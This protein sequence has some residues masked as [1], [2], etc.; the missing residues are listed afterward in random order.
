M[1]SMK[2]RNIVITGASSGIG[3]EC[4][5]ACCSAGAHV[6]LIDKD[7]K[8]LRETQAS[9]AGTGHLSYC[10]DIT[11]FESLEGIIA[12][13]VEK[14]GEISGLI[15]AAGIEMTMPFRVLKPALF[16]QVFSVNVIAGIE[17][18]R[19]ITKKRYISSDGAS[20]VYI[21][22]V[23][24]INGQPGKTAYCASKGAL[25][26]AVR[27]M[28]LELAPN[29]IRVNAVSPGVVDTPMSQKL[30]SEIPEAAQQAVISMHP[31]GL[32][33]PDDIAQA[34]LFLLSDAARWITGT[35]LIIDGGY[36]AG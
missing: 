24:G 4:A 9:L 23:M 3:R 35:N 34:C 8:G 15:H 14:L 32:G 11:R 36:S 26:A 33:R 27:S 10:Q 18:A 5:L 20:L 21:A 28:A 2:D 29:N 31:L 30:F 16:N 25:I 22:S 19:T 7:D 17:L 12:A 13:S 6:V 1:H